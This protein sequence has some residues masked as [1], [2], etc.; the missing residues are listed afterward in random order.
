MDLYASN[1]AYSTHLARLVFQ[2]SKIQTLTGDPGAKLTLHSAFA[3]RGRI[4]SSGNRFAEELSE[5]DF[6][7]LVGIWER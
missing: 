4:R 1:T 3:I 7:E 5:M 6:D 2:R